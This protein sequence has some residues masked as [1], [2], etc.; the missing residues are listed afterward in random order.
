M[1][2]PGLERGQP[3]RTTATSRQRVYLI[4]PR[5]HGA[6][7]GVDPDHPPYEGGAAS[8]ARRRGF[9]G[10]SRTNGG[11][12]QS[13][14]GLPTAHP[15]PCVRETRVEPASR[16]VWAREVYLLPSLP[17]AALLRLRPPGLP[18][19]SAPELPADR[20]RVHLLVSRQ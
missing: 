14:A 19:R 9:R 4:P 11:I 5:A 3:S 10:W 15:E 2:P 6:A 8:R 17:Q 7:P 13:H 20:R 1:R 18:P 16:E 12:V